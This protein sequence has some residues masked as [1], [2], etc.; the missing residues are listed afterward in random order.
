M[1]RG[2]QRGANAPPG[3]QAQRGEWRT[4]KRTPT[5]EAAPVTPSAEQLTGSITA[6]HAVDTTR[7]LALEGEGTDTFQARLRSLFT[8]TRQATGAPWS[9]NAVARASEGHI[10]A[11]AVYRLYTKADANPSLET[12]RVLA[13]VFGVDPDYFV[14]PGALRQQ[15]EQTQDAYARLEADPHIT[16]VSRRM[17]QMTEAD[18]LLLVEFARRL[19]DGHGAPPKRQNAI[20]V[21]EQQRL[22]RYDASFE[23]RQDGTAGSPTSASLSDGGHTVG[24]ATTKAPGQGLDR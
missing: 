17:G 24:G 22:E 23:M 9:F 15:Q 6:P 10:S 11:Q 1:S 5:G 16:F 8:T 21:E 4:W 12:I 3:G 2:N 7:D 19:T 20:P 13:S 14:R 18:K